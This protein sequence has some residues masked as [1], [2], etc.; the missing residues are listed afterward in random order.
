MVTMECIVLDKHLDF[1]EMQ[2]ELG[3][4]CCFVVFVFRFTSSLTLL[5]KLLLSMQS[6]LIG[7]FSTC[8][9]FSAA[10][11]CLLRSGM[12]LAVA[13]QYWLVYIYFLVFLSPKNPL[14]KCLIFSLPV[15]HLFEYS[16]SPW[17]RSKTIYVI[18]CTN[19]VTFSYYL[20]CYARLHKFTISYNSFNVC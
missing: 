4:D 15:L 1:D 8:Y 13:K 19:S 10:F 14:A 12:T 7:I 16:A 9:S 6:G 11:G 20:L 18:H 5:L 3:I 2:Q 17:Y